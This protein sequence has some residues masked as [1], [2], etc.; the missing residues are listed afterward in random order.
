MT[1]TLQSHQISE[2]NDHQAQRESLTSRSTLS[3]VNTSTSDVVDDNNEHISADNSDNT[4]EDLEAATAHNQKVIECQQ[5][6]LQ[7]V[8][9]E[10]EYEDNQRELRELNLHL[11]K[12]SQLTVMNMIN[13]ENNA[14]STHELQCQT[15]TDIASLSFQCLIKL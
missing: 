15:T 8:Q 6:Q 3:A 7:H 11:K 13:S 5:L 4:I 14:D 1:L 2:T 10:I 9:Q 12:D